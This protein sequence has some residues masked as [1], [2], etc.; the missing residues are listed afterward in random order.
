MLFSVLTDLP[1][2]VIPKHLTSLSFFKFTFTK[3]DHHNRYR[4]LPVG[5]H[6]NGRVIDFSVHFLTE[7]NNQVA[8]HD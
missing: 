7:T 4:N 8:N 3:V 1:M 5:C 2:I 6:Q